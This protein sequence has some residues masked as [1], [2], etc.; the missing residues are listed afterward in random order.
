MTNV[1]PSLIFPAPS[2]GGIQT[3]R[4][5]PTTIFCTAVPQP[6]IIFD[7]PITAERGAGTCCTSV[8]S[9]FQTVYR[10][11]ARSSSAR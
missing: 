4:C 3:R 1:S 7:F 10:T 5:S 8:P 11:R 6:G 9:D 2:A